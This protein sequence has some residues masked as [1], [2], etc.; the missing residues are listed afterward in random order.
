M[1]NVINTYLTFYQNE[2]R[3][4]SI[5]ITNQNHEAFLPT[6]NSTYKVVDS[7]E[8][9]VLSE[10]AATV[11]SNVLTGTINTT[12]TANVGE[13]YIIWKITDSNSYVYYHRVNLEVKELI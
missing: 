1:A 6:A 8:N 5:K 2:V 7:D 4:V 10:T 13:Y 9:I 12:V 3:P 11:S